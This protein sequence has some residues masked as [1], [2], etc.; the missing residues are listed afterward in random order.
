MEREL[1]LLDDTTELHAMARKCRRLADAISDGPTRDNLQSLADE[2][3]QRAQRLLGN[4]GERP[5][6]RW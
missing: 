4:T 2:Y 6:M 5:L 3:E 1:G